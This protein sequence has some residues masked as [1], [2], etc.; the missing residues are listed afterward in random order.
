[1]TRLSPL[2]MMFLYGETSNSKMHVGALLPMTPPADAPTDYLRRLIDDARAH[3]IAS[4]WNRK[5]AH[6]RLQYSP[7]HSWVV[8]KNFDFDYHV[9]R[10][11]LASPG[12]ERELGILIS[13]LHS[14]HLDL[15]RP[16][17]EVHLIEGL[18]G[19]RFAMYMKVHHSLVD[20]YTGMKILARSF[21]PDPD[22]ADSRLFFNVAAPQRPR[23]EPTSQTN[24][25]FAAIGAVGSAVSGGISSTFNVGRALLNTQIRRDGD[26]ALIAN[27]VQAPHSILNAHISRNRRFATQQY[28]T[29]RLKA[30]GAEHDATL[31]DVALAVIGGGLRRFLD[32]LGELPHRSLVSFVPVNVR[33]KGDVGGGNAVGAILVGMGTDIANPV[34]R[35]RGI[36]A[37]TRMSKAQ[38]QTMSPNEILA[39]TAALIAPAAT[40][41]TGAVTGIEPPWPYTFNLCVSNVPGPREP[42]YLR[43]SRLEATYPVSIPMHGMALNITLQSYADT[44]NFGFIGCRDTLPHLQRLAVYTGEALDDLEAATKSVRRSSS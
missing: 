36:T 22:D 41:V 4:P 24:P 21:S 39:Y 27:S 17:W 25:L 37:S 2:D 31:N 26:Y 42:L 18:E 6:H 15:S 10:S 28:A 23:P 9:R 43:G 35:L 40:Q 34:E 3:D 1:M 7:L 19:G 30:I 29:E 33:P 32:E 13:R 16:P 8:D 14:N 5:L 38:L 12:D 11:A 20:G 44:L